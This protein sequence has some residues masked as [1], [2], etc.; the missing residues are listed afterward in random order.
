MSPFGAEFAREGQ[1]EAMAGAICAGEQAGARCGTSRSNQQH[2]ALKHACARAEQSGIRR[3]AM[4]ALGV[5]GARDRGHIRPCG[6]DLNHC[7]RA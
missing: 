3:G 6:H 2:G 5:A 1:A 7:R 4:G